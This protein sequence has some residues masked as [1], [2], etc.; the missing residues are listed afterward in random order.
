[1]RGLMPSAS[2]MIPKSDSAPRTRLAVFASIYLSAPME[3]MLRKAGEAG[4]VIASNKRIGQALVGSDEWRTISEIF[5]CLTG[6]LVGYDEP[7]RKLGKAIT[8]VD[9]KTGKKYVFPVPE[10]FRG[11]RDL[12]LAV[13]HPDFTLEH[14]WGKII[15][16]AKNVDAL[17]LP[18]TNGWFRG[19]D[20]YDIPT[21]L[22]VHLSDPYRRFLYRAVKWI[23]MI[24][25]DIGS[26]EEYDPRVVY[27]TAL[28]SHERFGVATEVPADAAA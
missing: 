14:H 28:A 23:G 8:W 16:C 7:H 2:G 19:D 9:R 25:R 18:P 5:P 4:M 26:Y 10:D 3:E 11:E 13:N 20:K 17:R 6:T 1:M 24:T 15:V 21:G 27:A 22:H 12:L